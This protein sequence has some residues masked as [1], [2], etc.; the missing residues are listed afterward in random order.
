MIALLFWLQPKEYDYQ[1]PLGNSFLFYEAH[2]SGVACARGTHTL[3][4]TSCTAA[5]AHSSK[6]RAQLWNLS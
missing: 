1:K 2:R 4:A 5:L 3:S 6:S